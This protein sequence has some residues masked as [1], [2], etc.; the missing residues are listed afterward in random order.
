[1]ITSKQDII[2]ALGAGA[3]A[4]STSKAELWEL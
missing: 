4:V 1:M 2:Q 3:V